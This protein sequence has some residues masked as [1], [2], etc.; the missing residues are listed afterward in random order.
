AGGDKTN[1]LRAAKLIKDET[2]RETA[3]LTL[4][5]EWTQGELSPPRLRAQRIAAL[6]LEAGLGIE[7]GNHPELALL[8]ANELTEGPGRAA[9]LQETARHVVGS[10]P[11]AAFALSQMIPH[12]DRQN[13]SDALFANWAGKDTAA[14]IQWADQLADPAQ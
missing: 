11:N 5:T 1:A 4:V 12:A 8:W 14:A 10:D 9:V 6:G 13:F 7:L 3:L 2:E